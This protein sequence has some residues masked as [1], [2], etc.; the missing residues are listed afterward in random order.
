MGIRERRRVDVVDNGASAELLSEGNATWGKA[1]TLYPPRVSLQ[2]EVWEMPTTGLFRQS[3]S[4]P[5]W[6]LA[7]TQGA[8]VY[9]QPEL[10]LK[11]NGREGETLLHEFLHVLVESEASPQA[12]LW[13]REGV[14][15]ALADS[16][17][18]L[19]G[20]AAGL[21]GGE[22]DVALARPA[23]EAASQRAH[24]EAAKL[25]EALI[26]RYGLEQ[27]RQWLRSGAVPDAALTM[28]AQVR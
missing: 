11:K 1:R 28:A 18:R 27:V 7:S 9:L 22:L 15:E 19:G 17:E 6:V 14:V 16:S 3:T 13:L 8:R 2:P 10:V 20:R 23:S 4:E 25:V 12:P 5:G 21:R 26:H 24:A